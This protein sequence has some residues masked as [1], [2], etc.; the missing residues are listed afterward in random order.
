M[1]STPTPAAIVV[2]SAV[3]T[4]SPAHPQLLLV[5]LVASP[6][7]ATIYIST[8]TSA[9]STALKNIS[10]I[11]QLQYVMRVLVAVQPALVVD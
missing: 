11:L 3:P 7:M 6:Q 1:A 5:T 4:A 8:T 10:A 2:S 9:M